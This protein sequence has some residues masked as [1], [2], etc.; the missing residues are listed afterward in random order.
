MNRV[1]RWLPAGFVRPCY[2]VPDKNRTV[3]QRREAVSRSE[4]GAPAVRPDA[5]G[6][7]SQPER[8]LPGRHF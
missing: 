5:P 8:K 3:A 1:E 4:T 6:D 7:G 2:G